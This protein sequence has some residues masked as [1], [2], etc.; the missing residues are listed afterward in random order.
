MGAIASRPAGR[1]VER[2]DLEIRLP[3]IN[4]AVSQS[5]VAPCR[6]GCRSQQTEVIL[7]LLTGGQA[8]SGH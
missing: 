7:K 2:S 6:Q 8:T 5:D 1:P 4:A 3:T